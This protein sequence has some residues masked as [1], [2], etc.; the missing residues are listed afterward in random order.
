MARYIGKNGGVT[1]RE[2]HS[3]FPDLSE[4]GIFRDINT[5]IRAGVVTRSKGRYT[6]RD[7]WAYN[8]E[9]MEARHALEALLSAGIEA[10]DDEDILE[11]AAAVTKDLF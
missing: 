10:C 7:Y 4:R 5:L 8:L 1:A 6:V 9:N 3:V 2:L 11:K